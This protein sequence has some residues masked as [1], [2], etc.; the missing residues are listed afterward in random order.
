MS[1]KQYDTYESTLEYA[2][3]LINKY[4]YTVHKLTVKLKSKKINDDLIDTVIKFLINKKLLD[5]YRYALDYVDLCLSKL[6][7]EN[8]IKQK[9][10]NK[11]VN[12]L[13][14]DK[15]ISEINPNVL[16]EN[17][18]ALSKILLNKYKNNYSK[19]INSLISR[20]YSYS[21]IKEIINCEV[22]L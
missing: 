1:Y 19:V 4:D 14:I 7:G 3:K 16:N 9:L 15:A 12:S 11:G 6:K 17:L 18:I 22:E 20:G 10:I 2:L 21:K 5:D 8:Y 13:I